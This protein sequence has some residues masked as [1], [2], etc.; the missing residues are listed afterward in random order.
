LETT[1]KIH[2]AMV[3]KSSNDWYYS[4]PFI[5]KIWFSGA[6][7]VT[8][9]AMFDNYTSEF[10][11]RT[12]VYDFP[13]I[14]NNLELWRFV[15]S[16]C[17]SGPPGLLTIAQL[18]CLRDF[19]C[20]Y[21]SNPYDSGGGGG[22]A[23]F[24]L[25]LLFGATMIVISYS[26]LDGYITLIPIF[27]RKLLFYVIFLWSKRSPS[28]PTTVWFLPVTTMY[29]PFVYVVLAIILDKPYFDIIH[30][31]II[32]QIYFILACKKM[33]KTPEFLIRYF[34]TGQYTH[35]AFVGTGRQMQ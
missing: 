11:P 16:F 34:G 24:A 13:A 14:K 7:A 23:D 9:I 15:S 10:F 8:V 31:T 26:L 17:Y 32:G 6:V 21:E 29:V 35:A 19:S 22:T 5:T 3:M 30:G 33:I 12:L 1:V 18:H 2:V 25:M 20:R 28:N 4:L 27:T